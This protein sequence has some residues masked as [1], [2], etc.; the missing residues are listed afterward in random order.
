[1]GRGGLIPDEFKIALESSSSNSCFYLSLALD[2]IL[3]IGTI[4]IEEIKYT[5]FQ[6]DE[7]YVMIL[8]S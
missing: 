3:T 1:M 5:T 7:H 4:Q 2:L 8:S 6:I